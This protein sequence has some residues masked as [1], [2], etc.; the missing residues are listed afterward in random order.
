M[1]DSNY[2]YA[3]TYDMVYRFTHKNW[4]RLMRDVAA[5]KNVVWGD[6]GKYV[7]TLAYHLLDLDAE[8]AEEILEEIAPEDD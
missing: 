5:K 1:D 7:F 6:Y 2:I 3:E 8:A 4:E